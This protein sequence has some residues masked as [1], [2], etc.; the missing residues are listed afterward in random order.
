MI[1]R[2]II[3]SSLPWDFMRNTWNRLRLTEWTQPLLCLNL[4]MNHSCLQCTG[5]VLF[6]CRDWLIWTIRA[7]KAAVTSAGL[8][9]KWLDVSGTV[10]VNKAWTELMVQTSWIFLACLPCSVKLHWQASLNV[11]QKGK[12]MQC[13]F[14]TRLSKLAVGLLDK[15]AQVF[16]KG[17]TKP[18][19][20]LIKWTF[21]FTWDDGHSPFL[22]IQIVSWCIFES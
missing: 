13:V 21:F 15:L 5:C 8:L 6:Y 16:R 22:S 9:N 7:H 10:G 3:S 14:I 11:K 4:L 12:F 2:L 18:L 17:A 1:V 20:A 19:L